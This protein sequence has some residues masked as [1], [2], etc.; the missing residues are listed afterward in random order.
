MVE[1]GKKNE[2]NNLTLKFKDEWIKINS[3]EKNFLINFFS[4]ISTFYSKTL[5]QVEI[6]IFCSFSSPPFLSPSL[7]DSQ[8][9]RKKLA[10]AERREISHVTLFF[11]SNYDYEMCI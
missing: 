10:A 5:E 9:K 6:I 4:P 11:Y 3:I 2:V 7:K 8:A 1:K